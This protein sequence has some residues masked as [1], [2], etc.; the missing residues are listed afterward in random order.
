MRVLLFD[1]WAGG[2]HRLYMDRVAA[3]LAPRADLVVAGAPA[4]LAGVDSSIERYAIDGARPD[5]E[6]DRS[7]R[8]QLAEH[9]HAELDL[10]EEAVAAVRPDATLHL[11][12]DPIIR[13]LVRRPRLDTALSLIVFGFI[14]YKSIGVNMFP[15]VDIPMVTVTV[16]N[17]GMAPET[18]DREVAEII[19]ESVG[20]ISGIKT[21]RI[22]RDVEDKSSPEALPVTQDANRTDSERYACGSA[23]VILSDSK[24]SGHWTRDFSRSQARF[25]RPCSAQAL[26]FAAPR[27]KPASE[28]SGRDDRRRANAL[29]ADDR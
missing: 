5:L 23:C 10:L 2:H 12:A 11:Y 17:P 14:S 13:R 28:R 24:G 22:Y 29:P 6:P 20:T 18:M 16:M 26:H 21:L 15:K 4:T 27:S 3:T 1:W 7:R 25:L 19:E 8:A 9:A